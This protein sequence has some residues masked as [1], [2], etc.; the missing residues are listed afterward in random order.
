MAGHCKA[1]SYE[2][3]EMHKFGKL[4]FFKL[5]VFGNC[6]FVCQ[7]VCSQ[8]GKIIHNLLKYQTL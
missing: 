2:V 5:G 3:I 4:I 8:R 7:Y 6:V 1:N